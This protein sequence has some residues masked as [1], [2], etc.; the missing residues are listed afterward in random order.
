MGRSNIKPAPSFKEKVSCK[1]LFEEKTKLAAG[2]NLGYTIPN[3]PDKQ[4]ICDLLY[5]SNPI[6]NFLIKIF[7][8]FSF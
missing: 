7:N 1:D 5:S 3:L 4:Y 8:N 6:T 2:Q